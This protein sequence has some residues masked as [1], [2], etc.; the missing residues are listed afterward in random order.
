MTFYGR[1]EALFLQQW[2]LRRSRSD[3]PTD[4]SHCRQVRISQSR[5]QNDH[6]LLRCTSE[7]PD[8]VEHLI[9]VARNAP[10]HTGVLVLDANLE[11]F[12]CRLH[13]VI[14]ARKCDACKLFSCHG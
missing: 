11:C 7:I 12:H 14:V 8:E 2:F 5:G 13:G 3:M 6:R 1:H 4:V 10:K 9:H